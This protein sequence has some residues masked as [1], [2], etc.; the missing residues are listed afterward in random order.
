[1]SSSATT[2]SATTA[3]RSDTGATTNVPSVSP[4]L[5]AECSAALSSLMAENMGNS[6]LAIEPLI[7]PMAAL[8]YFRPWL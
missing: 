2:G 8:G 1:M 6:T 5:M 7:T 3:A 4:R